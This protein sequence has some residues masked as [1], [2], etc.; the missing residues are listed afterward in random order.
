M[1]KN[2]EALYILY[3]RKTTWTQRRVCT[4]TTKSYPEK[5]GKGE[6]EGF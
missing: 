4:T 6:V 2:R 3:I 1:F 5:K